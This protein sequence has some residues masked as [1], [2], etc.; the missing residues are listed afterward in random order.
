MPMYDTVLKNIQ[1]MNPS[2]LPAEAK[3]PK[4]E[5]SRIIPF[6]G[7]KVKLLRD[8]VIPQYYKNGKPKKPAIYPAGHTVELFSN[9]QGGLKLV[10]SYQVF[11]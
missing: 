2:Y 11:A 3:P 4:V 10:D 8:Y 9:H 5:L 7:A 1:R 6:G